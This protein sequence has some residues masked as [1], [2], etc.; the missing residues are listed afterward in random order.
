MDA[1]K[2]FIEFL[3]TDEAKKVFESYG[4]TAIK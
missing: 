3:K 2:K 4:F 1:S